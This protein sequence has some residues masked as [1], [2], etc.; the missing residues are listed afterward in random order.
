MNINPQMLS[1]VPKYSIYQAYMGN[2]TL[3]TDGIAIFLTIANNCKKGV[4][5]CSCGYDVYKIWS[6]GKSVLEKIDT[7]VKIVRILNGQ[8]QAKEFEDFWKQLFIEQP[9]LKPIS[10]I[11]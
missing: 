2:Q 1:H 8:L 9:Y 7:E 11:V 10:I 4:C 5:A 3:F 6:A